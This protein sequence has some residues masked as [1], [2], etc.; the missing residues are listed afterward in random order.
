MS[1]IAEPILHFVFVIKLRSNLRTK[2]IPPDVSMFANVIVLNSYRSWAQLHTIFM[3][4]LR[5]VLAP[6][7]ITI[8]ALGT[9]ENRHVD[10]YNVAR[11]CDVSTYDE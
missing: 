4:L 6:V 7:T 1:Q 11:A 5:D 3:C 8:L 9:R 10:A 2:D